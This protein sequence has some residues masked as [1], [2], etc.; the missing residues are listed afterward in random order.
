VSDDLR[1]LLR[2]AAT[3][4]ALAEL[5]GGAAWQRPL[6]FA[7]LCGCTASLIT[8]GRVTL[9]LVAPCAVYA[10]LV[11]VVEIAVLAALLR[12]RRNVPFRRAIDLFF[13]GHSGW[14]L[15]LLMVAA[16]FAFVPPAEAFLYTGSV[17]RW[18]TVG[19]AVIWSG[20]I[21]Y[22]FFRCVSPDRPAWNLLMQRTL[23]W[24]VGLILFGGASLWPGILGVLGQ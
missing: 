3:Y 6:W 13:M 20:Y 23:S 1:V 2:P 11:P 24:T 12:G 10:C 22:C 17:F 5:E 16:I 9:R 14:S 19:T 8:S 4:Q 7:F 21:D 15:W 18:T